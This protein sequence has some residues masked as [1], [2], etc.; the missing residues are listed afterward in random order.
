MAI[1]L[2]SVLVS[3]DTPQTVSPEQQEAI[4]QWTVVPLREIMPLKG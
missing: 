3:S 1:S 4:G 2:L